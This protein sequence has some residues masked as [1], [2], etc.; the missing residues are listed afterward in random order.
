[1]NNNENT[2]YGMND[3]VVGMPIYNPQ[4]PNNIVNPVNGGNVKAITSFSD[5]QSYAKGTI[6]RLPDFA[7]GQPF[8]ARV[9]RP[10]MLVLAK[11]GKIPNTLLNAAG[12]LFA[13]GGSGLDA[14]NPNM[15]K[16]MYE[17][18]RVICEASLVE[19]TVSDIESA[20]MELTDEQIMAIFNYT[21][22]GVK[23][24]ENFREE[25]GDSE[26]NNNF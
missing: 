4:Q 8:V 10:S 17:V 23:A 9:K 19:P 21:Q 20:G 6:V 13:E 5:L 16:D 12:T 18:C 26:Y 11:S 3:R 24:L 15:L 2:N 7:E 22:V 14:D 1:M 25:Q